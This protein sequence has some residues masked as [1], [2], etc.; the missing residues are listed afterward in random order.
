LRGWKLSATTGSDESGKAAAAATAKTATPT[1]AALKRLTD[2]GA[3]A[4]AR[5]S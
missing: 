3:F 4:R 2:A 1:T 5:L